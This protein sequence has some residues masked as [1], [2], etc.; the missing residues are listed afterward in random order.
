ME[1]ETIPQL[2]YKLPHLIDGIQYGGATVA[3]LGPTHRFLCSHGVYA[4]D[5]D[6]D[7]CFNVLTGVIVVNWVVIL[8]CMFPPN[9]LPFSV[10]SF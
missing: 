2:T 6:E 4:G 3:F 8:G 5:S 10:S 9:S 7:G 1:F